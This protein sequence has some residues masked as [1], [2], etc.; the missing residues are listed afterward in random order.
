VRKKLLSAFAGAALVLSLTAGCQSTAL[1][2]APA[3]TEAFQAR[4]L[5]VTTAVAGGGYAAA[6]EELTALETDLDAAAADGSVSFARHQRIEAAMNAVRADVQ[7]SLDAQNA[8][9]PAPAPVEPTAPA[10]EEEAPP[11]PETD[12]EEKAREK[13]EKAAEEAN[14]EAEEDRKKAEEK[15]A[16][17]AKKAAED[18]KKKAEED[19]KNRGNTGRG[20]DDDGDD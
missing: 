1:D 4:I 19:A 14:K 12:A 10:E 18:A 15:A 13:A 8:P 6:L 16:E 11:A 17:D 20:E 3:Q 9:E 2:I 7:A 5:A